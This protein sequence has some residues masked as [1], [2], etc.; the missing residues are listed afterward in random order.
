MRP[1]ESSAAPDATSLRVG[2]VVSEYH[3]AITGAMADAA[4]A[5]FLDAGG[6]DD[7][8]ITVPAAGSFELIALAN[9]LARRPD[10]DAVVTIGC[11][12]AGETTHDQYLAHAV[13]HGLAQITVATSIPVAFGVLTCQNLDQAKARAG[14][15]VGN[16]GE[17]VMIAAIRTAVELRRLAVE[18]KGVANV[19]AT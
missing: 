17:E 12:I 1:S 18:P 3:A 10:I 6:L 16:K 2:L 14:G 7:D 15:A 13:A 9:G 4:R 11:I 8:L 19:R 5:I